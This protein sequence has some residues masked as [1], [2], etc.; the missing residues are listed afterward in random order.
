MVVDD[1]ANDPR[2]A[3]LQAVVNGDIGAYLGVPLRGREAMVIGA[4]C[5]I[6]PVRRVIDAGELERL[7]EFGKVVE[8]QLDLIRRLNEQRIE[9]SVAT[10]E[11]ARA[12]R[13][14]EIVPWYQPIVELT[15]GDVV[16]L[17]ALARWEHP[18]GGVD[19]PRRFIPVA[20][21]SD[22]IIDVDLA[23][24]RRAMSDLRRW[25]ET[26]P[27]LR[28]SVN[29]SAR[30]LIHPDSASVLVQV[31]ADSGVEPSSITLELTETSRVD[32]GNVNI[33]A[34]VHQLRTLGFQV[35]LDDFGT[36]WSSLDH[37]LWLTVDGIKIDRAVAVALGTPVGDALTSAVTGLAAALNLR[38]TIEGVETSDHAQHARGLGCDYGQGYYWGFPTA[39]EA[40]TF[41]THPADFMVRP[42]VR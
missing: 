2:F 5:V 16:G 38:T 37:L 39:A 27:A 19:D 11:M 18:D 14:G 41:T 15:T 42:I 8:D 3:H 35:W 9:G 25:H 21:D 13:D 34:V 29:L 33:P 1:A 40:V 26:R 32:T 30:H 20:E 36:G 17:E 7:T 23:V 22:L 31:A 28:M 10:D 24:I 6:D 12:T 4:V